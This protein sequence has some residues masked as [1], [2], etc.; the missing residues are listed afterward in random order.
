MNPCIR[1]I[2]RT[3]L[4][5]A[6]CVSIAPLRAHAEGPT[7]Q[8][9]G[10]AQ[11]AGHPQAGCTKTCCTAV[12]DGQKPGHRVVS[13]GIADGE[14]RILF[15][16]TPDLPAQLAELSP[17]GR[18]DTIFLTHAHMGHYSGLLHLG[19][20]AM[21]AASVD[22]YAMPR[23]TDFLR[24]D[25]PW[26]LL[27][28]QGHISLSTLQPGQVVQASPRVTVSAFLVPHRDEISETAGFIIAGPK[29]K[30]AFI[31]D[32]DK[33]AKWERPLESLLDSVDYAFID[34]TFFADGEVAR[35]M[36]E[37]PHP[38]VQ[39]T[40]EAL[41]TLPK[42]SRRK[43]IFIHFNHTNPLLDPDSGATTTVLDAGYQQAI[44]G[45]SFSL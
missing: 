34:A 33:W 40:M 37:I 20:E 23:M 29:K 17:S 6:L 31:P 16:A 1:A 32:I 9:L 28:T 36:S 7:L 3:S 11:D 8:V 4:L 42:R 44:R 15:E 35:D 30:V 21:G 5:G 38:F 45:M 2:A 18:I 27:S 12:R 43:V 19:R 25:R 24:S 14:Y 10:V 39:E 26:S 41:A 22:V 13:L